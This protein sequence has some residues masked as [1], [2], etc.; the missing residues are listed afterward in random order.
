MPAKGGGAAAAAAARTDEEREQRQLVEVRGRE[1]RE[2]RRVEEHEEHRVEEHEEH[3][4]EPAARRAEHRQED[5]ERKAEEHVL[6]APAAAGH[7]AAGV[8]LVSMGRRPSGVTT[9]KPPA[10]GQER[11]P[12]SVGTNAE[13]GFAAFAVSQ[14]RGFGLERPPSYTRHEHGV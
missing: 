10:C 9:V 5:R 3:R 1:G 4:V 6:E 7:G 14:N 12:P 13:A 8:V 11:P 2:E